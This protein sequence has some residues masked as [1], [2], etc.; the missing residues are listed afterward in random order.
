MKCV[1]VLLEF[2]STVDRLMALRVLNYA[3]NLYMELTCSQHL[4]KLPPIFPIVLYN[5]NGR[6]TAVTDI[7]GLIEPEP[8]LGEYSL[9]FRYFKLVENERLPVVSR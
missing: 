9:G 8:S 3:V 6:W 7:V 2:Q 5:R 1:Y 4:E